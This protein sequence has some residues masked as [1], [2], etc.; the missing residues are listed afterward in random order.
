MSTEIEK[1]EANYKSFWEKQTSSKIKQEI[2][3]WQKYFDKHGRAYALHGSDMTP[4]NTLA[5][6]TKVL[7]L[8]EILNRKLKI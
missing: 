2:K 3:S 7:I 1:L 6:G 4:P 5:D 8:K